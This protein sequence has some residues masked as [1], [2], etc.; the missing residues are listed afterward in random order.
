MRYCLVILCTLTSYG[1]EGGGVVKDERKKE[2]KKE[3]EK[4]R[5]NQVACS[6]RAEE[7]H[8]DVLVLLLG[9]VDLQHV[10]LGDGAPQHDVLQL[11]VGEVAGRVVGRSFSNEEVS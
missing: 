6:V 8:D 1:G 10:V 5:G 7:L 4:E 2:R 11:P 3:K 9:A